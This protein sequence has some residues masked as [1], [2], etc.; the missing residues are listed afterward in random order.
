LSIK[1]SCLK[2]P[3]EIGAIGLFEQKYGDLVSV[4]YLGTSGD[5]KN[6]YTKEFCGGPHAKSTGQLGEFKVVK[7]ESLGSGVRRIYA[8]ISG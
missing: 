7:E 8:T 4:Y 5:I 6:A 2:K 3:Q 1:S